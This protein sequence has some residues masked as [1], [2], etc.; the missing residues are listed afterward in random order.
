[1]LLYEKKNNSALEWA[2]SFRNPQ[3]LLHKR[4]MRR[5]WTHSACS[6]FSPDVSSPHLN[7]PP[8]A[9]WY[10][11][12]W[13]CLSKQSYFY[14]I[15][16]K[17]ENHLPGRRFSRRFSLEGRKCYLFKPL[18][19]TN[20]RIPSTECQ[21]VFLKV[22]SY[23]RAAG[24]SPGETAPQTF[25]MHQKQADA[26]YH[27]IHVLGSILTGSRTCASVDTVTFFIRRFMEGVLS[28]N[29]S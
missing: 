23:G 7:P 3:A 5:L 25:A 10:Y 29:P 8:A 24:D 21:G 19:H 4:F 2:S 11:P 22:V 26:L 18:L 9:M 1:M 16:K 20:S 14:I 17:K 27:V 13:S 6:G 28:V 15:M 12:E